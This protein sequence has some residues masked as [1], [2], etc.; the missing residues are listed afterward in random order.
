MTE[1]LVASALFMP[2][3]LAAASSL[4]AAFGDPARLPHPVRWTGACIARL[5]KVLRGLARGPRAEF[6]AGCV[7]A[8]AVAGGV[9]V[10][11]FAALYLA[12]RFSPAAALALSV[13]IVWT[14][15]SIKS[16][17]GEASAV[18]G[19]LEEGRLEEARRLLS[20]I[21]GRDTQNLGAEQVIRA[22]IETVSENTSDAIVAPLF[23][24]VL[25]GPALM[26]AYKAVNTLDSM[27]G[28]RNA[29]YMYFGRASALLD[30]AANFI[31]ARLTSLLMV[32]AS[33]ILGYN[34]KRAF[35]TVLS[36][37]RNHASPNSGMPEAATAGA[38]GVVLG[39]PA[40]YAGV[41]TER[42]VIDGARGGPGD[43]GMDAG[44]VERGI[45][46]M[47]CTSALMLIISACLGALMR[48]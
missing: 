33:F 13:Y 8:A 23:Y 4:E 2:V 41:R 48:V 35:K 39:G 9:Y 1:S 31:P 15:L 26:A 42:P 25:G 40:T 27:V 6:A 7:L 19:A 29:R 37:G 12:L 24:L 18:L 5:E 28:Y 21:V 16:L 44:C 32:C 3:V 20:R 47:L 34:W 46:M 22:A 43:P 17:R 38:L 10:F 11:A 36:D 14:S 45:R 30:D